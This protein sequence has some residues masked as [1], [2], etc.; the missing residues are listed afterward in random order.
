MDSKLNINLMLCG[1]RIQV[2][3]ASINKSA[4]QEIEALLNT[5]DLDI[6]DILKAYIQKCQEHAELEDRL[7]HIISKMEL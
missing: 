5:Q 2:N 6:K 3:I 4:K 1:R 7:Q